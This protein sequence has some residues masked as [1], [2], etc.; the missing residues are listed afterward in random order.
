MIVVVSVHDEVFEPLAEWTL[1]KN[2]LQYC[3]K[4]GY[5][6]HYCKDGGEKACGRPVMAKLPPIP[7]THYPMGWGKMFLLQEAMKKYPNAEWFF[8]TDCDVMITNFDTKIEDIIETHAPENIHILIPADCNGINCG[9]M[10]IRNSPVGK[11][12]IDTV[13]SGIPLYRHWYMFEN[14]L[15]QDLFVGSHLEE[16]GP[17]PGGTFWSRVGR[18]LPQRVFNSYDYKN[19]PRLKHR[20]DYKDILGTD[21]QWQDGDFIIQWPGTDLDFRIREAEKMYNHIKDS[22]G[23]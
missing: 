23:T 7:E 3:L 18:V 13:V 19:L 14:Q 16:T 17:T 6:L 20:K 15:I 10:L 21:G 12:F 8:S 22:M 9:N 1:Y 11:A 2:K 4:H 5:K